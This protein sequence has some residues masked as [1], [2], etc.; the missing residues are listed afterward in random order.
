MV[1]LKLR[2]TTGN[3]VPLI[4]D[5]KEI[6]PNAVDR[7]LLNQW[8]TTLITGPNTIPHES[9]K[10]QQLEAGS[11]GRREVTAAVT[12]TDAETLTEQE[13]PVLLALR[14]EERA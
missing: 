10:Q 6:I 1:T 8:A 5:A 9:Y 14:D 2:N 13:M 4:D 7:R 11:Y 12:Y 3:N